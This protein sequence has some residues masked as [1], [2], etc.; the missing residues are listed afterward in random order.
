MHPRDSEK[1]GSVH[2][3][4]D[5]SPESQR[6]RLVVAHNDDDDR[7]DSALAYEHPHV[8]CF[9]A[10]NRLGRFYI[11]CKQNS[12]GGVPVDRVRLDSACRSS[13]IL[14]PFPLENGFPSEFLDPALCHWIVSSS[15]SSS[16]RGT[17][18]TVRSPVLTIKKRIDDGF[19]CTL[20][21]KEQP[22]LN[23]LRFYL[24]SEAC[25]RL[26]NDANCRSMLDQGCLDK[27]NDFLRQIHGKVRPERTCAVLG[28]TYWTRGL[29]CQKDDVALVFSNRFDGNDNIVR[30]ME[31]YR[32][33]LVLMVEAFEGFHDLPDHDVDDD[34]DDKDNV[35]YLADDDETD[36]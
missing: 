26:L 35:Y 22:L 3:H 17:D 1:T 23:V 2:H 9:A 13:S 33:K 14:L 20:A 24:G 27:L 28:Q 21:A 12:F 34:V 36:D 4:D 18:G 31:R 11:P 10:R 6:R 7:V 8:L 15:S 16:S 19:S 30:V 29:Y 5:S 32:Q 25:H